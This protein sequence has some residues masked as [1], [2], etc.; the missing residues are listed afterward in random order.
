MDLNLIW[1]N[2]LVLKIL[3]VQKEVFF[4][5]YTMIYSQGSYP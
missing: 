2:K 4:I 3:K 1:L 5:L